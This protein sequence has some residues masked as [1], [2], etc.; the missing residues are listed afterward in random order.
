MATEPGD[1]GLILIADGDSDTRSLVAGVLEQAGYETV[2][3]MS[4]DEILDAARRKLPRLVI[5]EVALPGLSGYEVCHQLR[6]EFGEALPIVFLSGDRTEPFDRV[7]G[8]LIGADDYLVKPFAPDELLA[9]V[10]RLA[11]RTAPVPPAVASKLTNREMEVLRLLAEGLEQDEIAR[12]LFI[13]R[14]TVGTHIEN[15][16]RKLGVRSRAQAVAVAY[17]EDLV[18]SSS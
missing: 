5:L 18:G 12:Q 11:R 7:A 17:R 15:I 16:M 8:F 9:R 4:G 6:N 14:K 3:A 10:R 2:A 1:S 13:T